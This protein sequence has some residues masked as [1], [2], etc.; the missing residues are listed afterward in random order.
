MKLLPA[1]AWV[2]AAAS[3]VGQV[4]FG[5]PTTEEDVCSSPVDASSSGGDLQQLARQTN[6]IAQVLNEVR[7]AVS[8]TS[9]EHH[10]ITSSAAT[11]LQSTTI[12][13]Y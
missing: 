9:S 5:Q 1:F 7:D 4:V 11:L 12:T 6:Q 8:Q 3:L 2:L 10:I 13:L